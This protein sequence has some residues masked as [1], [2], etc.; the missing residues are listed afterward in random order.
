MITLLLYIVLVVL[1]GW[2]A[3]W[4]LGNLAPGHPGI[5][6]KIVWVVTVL[7]V[8]LI[9]AQAI[10]LSDIPVPHLR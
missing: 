2:F 5:I 4:V 8:V 7:F 9:V 1:L 3:I 10:G 6:D